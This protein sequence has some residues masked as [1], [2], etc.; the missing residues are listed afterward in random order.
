MK[1]VGRIILNT[2]GLIFGN[3]PLRPGVGGA[4]P[5]EKYKSQNHKDDMSTLKDWS[6]GGL[7]PTL[8]IWPG[9]PVWHVRGEVRFWRASTGHVGRGGHC[10]MLWNP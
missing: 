2:I 4:G 1:L 7:E 8:S 3:L 9:K 6:K 5:T 10:M